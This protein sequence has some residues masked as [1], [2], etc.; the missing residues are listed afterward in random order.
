[1]RPQ[2]EP[3]GV[4]QVVIATGKAACRNARPS[5]AADRPCWVRIEVHVNYSI[6]F[7][8]IPYGANVM[9]A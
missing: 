2:N 1:M 6:G 7:W 4:G 3:P 8:Q 5:R 9:T